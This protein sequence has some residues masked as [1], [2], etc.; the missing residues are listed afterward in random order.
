[1]I[2]RGRQ[3]DGG[4]KASY[5]SP[6]LPLTTHDLLRP[7]SKYVSLLSY[8]L[9]FTC[10]YHLS[11][12]HVTLLYIYLYIY[13]LSPLHHAFLLYISPFSYTLHLYICIAAWDAA[14]LHCCL[15]TGI[16]AFAAHVLSFSG[17]QMDSPGHMPHRIWDIRT[18]ACFFPLITSTRNSLSLSNKHCDQWLFGVNSAYCS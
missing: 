14:F 3:I 10:I 15:M 8:V 4:W 18:T 7:S 13:H 2:F 6:F 5:R 12:V 17:L 1:M 9:P 11:P 16:Q